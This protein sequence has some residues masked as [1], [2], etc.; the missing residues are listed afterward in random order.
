MTPPSRSRGFTLVEIL[1][2]LSVL[3][4]I[5]LLLLSA[6]TGAGRAR[7]ILS[8][9]SREFR[10]V[11]LAL[12]RIGTELQGAFAAAHREDT[13]LTCREDQ[14]SG[15]PAATLVFLSFRLPEAGGIRPPA[16]TV[17]I[18]YFPRIGADGRSLD[19]Y[20]EQSDLPMIENRI[21]SSE[22]LVAEGLRGFRVEL[23]DGAAWVREWPPPGKPKTALPK[24]AAVTMIDVR[25]ETFR[26]EIPIPLAGVE[27]TALLSG[28]RSQGKP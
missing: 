28:R 23:W 9:R 11:R 2:S 16:D 12:D 24:K 25:G 19:L 10:Q 13:A 22:S 21:P 17:K 27:G 14:F 5:L 18:K 20:R 3:S 8:A 6:F 7:D 4:V 26:R 1:L 15:K